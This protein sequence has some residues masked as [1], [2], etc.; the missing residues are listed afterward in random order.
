[1][2]R[3]AIPVKCFWSFYDNTQFSPFQDKMHKKEMKKRNPAY[4]M[5]QLKAR[6]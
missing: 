2:I 1:M 3:M 5:K 6:A 4:K